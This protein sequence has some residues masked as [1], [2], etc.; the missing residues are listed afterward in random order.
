MSLYDL[1]NST[2]SPDTILLEVFAVAPWLSPLLLFF[3]FF[4]VFLGGSVRQKAR[5]GTADYSLWALLGSIS[6]FLIALFMTIRSGI[7]SLDNLI[8]VLSITI[9]SS[10]WFFLDRKASE[11]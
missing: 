3:V 6:I 7:L 9:L 8:I 1:P 2:V 10:V 4:V 5:T 11:L